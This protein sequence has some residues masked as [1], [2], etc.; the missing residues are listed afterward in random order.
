MPSNLKGI[1]CLATSFKIIK[2]KGCL[3]SQRDARG[4]A[5]GS[6]SLAKRR[7]DLIR[8]SGLQKP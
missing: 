5:I 7:H 2:D 6:Y 1:S 3:I 4:M 8:M